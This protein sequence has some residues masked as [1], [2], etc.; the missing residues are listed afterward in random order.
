LYAAKPVRYGRSVAVLTPNRVAVVATMRRMAARPEEHRPK[1]YGFLLFDERESHR[2]VEAFARDQFAWLDQ[3]A[4]SARIILFVFVHPEPASAASDVDSQLVAVEGAEAIE[5]PSLRVAAALNIRPRELPGI[6]FFTK[7]DL[8]RGPNE[9]LY[10]PISLELFEDRPRAET[11]VAQ[12]FSLVQEAVPSAAS[13]EQALAGLRTLLQEAHR[14]RVRGPIL[15]AI[16]DGLV[17]VVKFPGALIDAMGQ[18][19]ATE[20]AR[21]MVPE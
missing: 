16:R 12:I 15:A 19:W 11:E 18:A 4:A 13:P 14:Q 10:W 17:R 1:L 2:P 21:R 20:V 8:D 6:V 5:N 9:G 3:L 7:L